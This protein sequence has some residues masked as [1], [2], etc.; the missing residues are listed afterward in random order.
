MTKEG[1]LP[2]LPYRPSLSDDE[3]APVRVLNYP[4]SI[5]LAVQERP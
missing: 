5:V 4:V 2:V 1:T 3:V